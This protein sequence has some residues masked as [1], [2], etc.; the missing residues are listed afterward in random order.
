MR[1]PSDRRGFLGRRGAAQGRL[2]AALGVLV[3]LGACAGGGAPSVSSQAPS[4]P[5][6]APTAQPAPSA[7]PQPVHLPVGYGAITA[8]YIPLWVAAEMNAWEKYG[9]EVELVHL[10]GNTGP[11][12]LLAGQVPLMAL[13]GFASAPSMVE[14][15][16]FVI[17]AVMLPR[18]TARV[19]GAYGLD[20]PQELRGK[21][22]GV[23]RQGT[24]THFGALFAL[25]HWGLEADKDVAL[26]NLNENANILA[27]LISGAVDA[28]VL[29]DPNSFA[30]AKAGYPLLTDLADFPVEYNSAGFTTTRSYLQ[31]NRPL[32]LNFLRG[33]LEGHQRFFADRAFTVEVLRKYARIDDPDVLDQ[34]YAAYSEKYM[35]RVPLPSVASLQNILDDYASVNPRA[36]GLDAARLTD[37]SLVQD[38][39][40]DG[41]LRQLGLE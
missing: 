9:L 22:L 8:S 11:Q 37:A 19:Y 7:A 33:Y 6:A 26:V 15:A 2:M 40:R 3:L 25:R 21:R 36:R 20:N 17:F 4:A 5:A 16:D 24:L 18:Q 14:G 39:Q 12:S 1:Q 38:L 32:L 13:S 10:P 27:G 31:Q 30:A 34:T 29:T 28:G 23:T 41:F 35:A